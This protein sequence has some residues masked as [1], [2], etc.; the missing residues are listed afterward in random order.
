MPKSKLVLR[1]PRNRA[2]RTAELL[3]YLALDL[4]RAGIDSVRSTDVISHVAVYQL[5]SACI[6][7]C[8]LDR[9]G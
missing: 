3:S 1:R 4:R 9:Q 6:G 7:P 2:E 5:T 8:S